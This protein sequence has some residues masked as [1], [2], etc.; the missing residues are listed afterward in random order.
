MG[1]SQ[2]VISQGRHTGTVSYY[3][4]V[5]T[6]ICVYVCVCVYIYIY[7]YTHNTNLKKSVN[8]SKH[9]PEDLQLAMTE[10]KY[11]LQR[12]ASLVF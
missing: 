9:K 1:I 7:I 3:T 5:Y 8:I 11:I 2:G 4:Y 12:V 10:Y 6:H